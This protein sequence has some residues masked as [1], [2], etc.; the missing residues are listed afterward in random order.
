MATSRPE[1]K[2]WKS[3]RPD[4]RFSND[5]AFIQS[6]GLQFHL[7]AR[8]AMRHAEAKQPIL[9]YMAPGDR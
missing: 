3:A 7:A 5:A 1:K 9:F 4:E 6:F 2:A 8:A